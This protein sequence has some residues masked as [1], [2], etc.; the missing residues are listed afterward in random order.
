MMRFL[1]FFL[2]LFVV[3]ALAYLLS[4]DRKSIKFRYVIQLIIIEIL[5]GLFLFHTDIGIVIINY[6][7]YGFDALLSYAAAGSNFVFGG[8]VNKGEFSFFTNVLMPIV[9]VSAL[10]GILQYIRLLQLVIKSVGWLLSKVNGMGKLESFN[11]VSSLILGQSENFIAYKNILSQI[12]DKRMYTMAATAMSTVSLA[13]VGSYMQ[14][15]PPK[16]VVAALVLNMFSTFVILQMINPYDH[17]K[18]ISFDT[19]DST[20]KKEQAFFEMLSEYILDGFKVAIIVGAMLVGFI[21]IIAMLNDLCTRII[22]MS[23]QD[24]LGYIFYPIAWLLN[25]HGSETLKAASIMATKIV[26]N[27]FVAMT[28]L[29]ETLANFS[30]HTVGVISVFLVSFANFGSIGIIVGAVHGLNQ[31]Q[32]K[33]VAKYGMK[34]LLNATM[35]SFLSALIA[36]LVI[37]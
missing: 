10:I 21:A 4:S 23:F 32:A 9:L 14:L 7:S 33:L 35:V 1:F 31:K 25:I 2:G 37:F 13:I 16:Y 19:M 27:E 12:S 5:L 20:S 11:A 3:L 17:T 18:E 6:I 28:Y 30:H 29:K 34:I 8:M 24:L 36:S 22:G 26:S 15:I